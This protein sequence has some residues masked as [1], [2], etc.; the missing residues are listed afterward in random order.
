LK[1]LLDTQILLWSFF[2]T[3]KLTKEIAEII[4]LEVN[5]HYVSFASLFEIAIKVNIGKL[6]IPN[7]FFEK[8]EICGYNI[9]DLNPLHLAEYIKLPPTHKDP[10]D[11]M[12]IAQAISE[13]LTIL[14]SDSEFKYYQCRIITN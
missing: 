13:N 1:I 2:D 4:S 9:L 10:F 5:Q 3:K 14:T 12:I 8:I 6:K 7:S 11:R